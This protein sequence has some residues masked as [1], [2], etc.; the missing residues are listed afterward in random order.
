[1]EEKAVR[2]D[3]HAVRI[4]LMI[5]L[6]ICYGL[7]V[8]E[9]LTKTGKV[10]QLLAKGFTAVPVIAAF[11]TRRLTGVQFKYS[12]S[13]KVWKNWKAWLFSAFVPGILIG[14]GAVLYYIIFRGQ[15]S[16][17]CRYGALFGSDVSVLVKNPLIFMLVCALISA[18]AV[19]IQLLELGEEIGW[20]QYLLGF[21]KEKYGYRKAVFINGMEWGLAHLP[22]IWF[23]FN[24]SLENF[25]A[26]WSNMVLMMLLCVVLGTIISY[27]TI[28]TGNCMYAAIIHGTVNVA[29]EIPVCLSFDMKNGLL[30]PNPTGIVSMIPL[31]ILAL[32][33]LQRMKND[34][35]GSPEES[36]VQ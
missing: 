14:I 29:A 2:D 27:I 32:V 9:L 10:Y 1:M 26:P 16:G 36:S 22:L 5:V 30:G 20:R 4:Y 24:Y 28:R 3:R 12:L 18:A 8:L 7:G 11:L 6:G 17:V 31:I 21:Q 15:Y 13:L 35:M 34:D 23:G 25:G 33:L 19:P